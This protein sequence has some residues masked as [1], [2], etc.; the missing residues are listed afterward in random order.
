M[1]TRRGFFKQIAGVVAVATVAPKELIEPIE[2]SG[3]VIKT[4]LETIEPFITR[5]LMVGD[6]AYTP[7]QTRMYQMLTWLLGNRWAVTENFQEHSI[8]VAVPNYV[9]PPLMEML[10][11]VIDGYRPAGVWMKYDQKDFDEIPLTE[12]FELDS[13]LQESLPESL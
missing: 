11:D 12:L 9:S 1:S 3:A 7:W 6:W 5:P 2:P 4:T 8:T 10:K 13:K